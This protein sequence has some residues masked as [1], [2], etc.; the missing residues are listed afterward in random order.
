MARRG[1]RGDLRL[2][3]L[4]QTPDGR[5]AEMSEPDDD[6]Y[7]QLILEILNGPAEQ[8]EEGEI[9]VQINNDL[10]QSLRSTTPRES[11]LYIRES[12]PL[13]RQ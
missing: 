5:D 3:Q 9:D 13:P 7:L 11:D 1:Q 2:A 10:S 12:L 6:P 8:C 4:G